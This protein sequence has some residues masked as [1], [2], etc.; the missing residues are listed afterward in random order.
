MDYK[1]LLSV[2]A[3]VVGN[4][5]FFPYIRDIFLRKTKPHTY[6]WLIWT[7]T[8]G[9]GVAGVILGG[10][11]WGVLNLFIGTI[12]VFSVFLFSLKYG[13]KNITK[14]DTIILA[15][16]LISIIIWW[17]LKQPV[18]SILMI[19]AID[20]AGYIPSFRKT[21]LEPWSETAIAWIG[22]AV[23]DSIAIFALKEFNVLTVTYMATL[24]IANIT[25]LLICL[26]RRTVV[27][28]P[29]V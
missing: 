22:F 19:S 10:G 12:F 20:F 29:V 23:S 18:L 24:A 4:I 13:S 3:T 17:Q 2:F 21:Y 14:S 11:S 7:I 1:I 6:T 8:Q 16:A 5:A 15:L 26:F 28:E 25:L 9:T 27:K